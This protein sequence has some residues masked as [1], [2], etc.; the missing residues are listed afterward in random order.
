MPGTMVSV[1]G[2]AYW[3]ITPAQ[4][5]SLLIQ[6]TRDFLLVDADVEY[7]GEIATTNLFI[8][9]ANIGQELGKFPSD[10]TAKIVLYCT[11]G[12]HSAEAA[13]ILVQAGYTRVMNLA[14]GIIAW[15]QQGYVTVNNRRTMT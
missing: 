3:S 7:I 2:G 6:P 10:K 12:V 9:S 5:Y 4:L 14:G 1:T 11:S 13:V 15:Q 8:N